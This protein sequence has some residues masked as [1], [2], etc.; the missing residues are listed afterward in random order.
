MLAGALGSGSASAENVLEKISYN[1]LPGGRVEVTLQLSAPANDPQ[2]FTTD[3][4]PRIALDLAD[5]RSALAQRNVEIN[6][7]STTAV[8]AVEAAGR[9]RVVVDLVRPSSYESK[10]D[11]RNL[12]LT[13][14]NGVTGSATATA[15][16]SNDPNKAVAA[17]GVEVSNVDFRRGKNGEGRVVIT[18]T[19]EGA[20]TD[21]KR[22]G[23][24]ITLDL[25]NAKLPPNLAQRLDLLDFATPVQFVEARSRG[26]GARLEITAKGPY[27][28]LAYQSGN[29]YVLEISPKK[30]EVDKKKEKGAPPEYTGARVTFNFQDIPTRSVLQLIADVSDLNI[31]VADSV[32]GNVTLRLINVPWDQA[33]DLVLQAKGLDKRRRDNVIWVAPQKEIAEREQAL[34]DARIA[35]EQRVELDS[36]YIKVSYG[37][38]KDIA[39][40]L[41]SKSGG[42]GGGGG[43]GNETSRGFLSSRGSV[44]FDERTNTLL[45]NDTPEKLV[46]VRNLVLTLDRPVQQVLIESRIVIANDDFAKELGVRFGVSGGYEDNNGNVVSLSGSQVAA[47]TMANVALNNRFAGNRGTPVSVPGQTPGGIATPSLGNRLGVN[48]PVSSPAGSFGLAILGADYLLDL[49]LSAAQTEARGEVISSPRV[50]TANQQEAV[51]KQGQEIGYVTLQASATGGAGQATVNFKDAVLELKVTPTITNDERVVLA[52]NVKKDNIAALVA[53]PGGGFVP[54]IDKREINTTVLVDDGQ[55]VVLGGVYEVETRDDVKKVP[56]LGDIPGVGALFRNKT[57]R[58]EKAEL[59]IFVTPRILNESLK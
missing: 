21:V 31:V 26:A 29:E 22:E 50:I 41:T 1:T 5:T 44:T 10:I 3:T 46:E 40:L 48:M 43:G 23:D 6:T 30:A 37:K 25:Y 13:I 7:G 16:V 17:R 9:T 35:L 15:M 59:L 51:I 12:I 54:Q 53:N 36:A 57:S 38:A 27:E 19:G 52:L 45:V 55:T 34:E 56:F 20:T 42:G 33:L 39:A 2:I 4:P 24:N 14:G 28:Q 32:T 58:N 49:E 8:S 47:D 11:G 18:F